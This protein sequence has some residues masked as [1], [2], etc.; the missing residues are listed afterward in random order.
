MRNTISFLLQLVITFAIIYIVL[1]FISAKA[2][3]NEE[4]DYGQPYVRSRVEIPIKVLNPSTGQIKAYARLSVEGWEWECLEILWE[5]ESGWR[6]TA[7]NPRSTAYGIAQFLNST[8]S[9][10]DYEKSSDA[11][12][13]VDAGLQYIYNRYGDACTALQFHIRNN[14][15]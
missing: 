14:Y 11:Y 5:K 13:Q 10:T 9:L 6:S 12:I 7:Q 1:M 15:Y 3:S 4:H 2:A 8:W